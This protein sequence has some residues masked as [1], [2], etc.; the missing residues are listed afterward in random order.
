MTRNIIGIESLLP[1]SFPEVLAGLR[2]DEEEE[3]T[4]LQEP[5]E[6]EG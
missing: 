6:V 2:Q 4:L 1:G 5:E 3:M